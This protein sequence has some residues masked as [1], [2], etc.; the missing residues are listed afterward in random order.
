M[1]TVSQQVLENEIN[2]SCMSEKRIAE[3]AKNHNVKFS[4]VEEIAI[5]CAENIDM[6]THTE[7]CF[8]SYVIDVL[9]EAL[10]DGYIN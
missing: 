2:C 9:L 4:D 8:D 1:N 10:H 6:G 5:E 7:N 3:I